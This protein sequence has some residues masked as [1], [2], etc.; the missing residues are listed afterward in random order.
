MGEVTPLSPVVASPSH[1]LVS[2]NQQRFWGLAVQKEFDP[3]KYQMPQC[4]VF[5][6]HRTIQQSLIL[7]KVPRACSMLSTE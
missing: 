5:V 1:V 6:K 7:Q 3:K 2:K 4:W